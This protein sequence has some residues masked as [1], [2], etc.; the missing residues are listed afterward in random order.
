VL[1]K[2]PIPE[3]TEGEV[4]G[5]ILVATICGSDIHTI[6]GRRKEPIPR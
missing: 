3:I 6:Q 5:K 2:A 4:L 1:E